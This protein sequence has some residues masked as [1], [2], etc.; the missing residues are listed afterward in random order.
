MQVLDQA[1]IP[2]MKSRPKRALLVVLA[3]LA[4]F[5][6]LVFLLIIYEQIQELNKTDNERYLKLVNAW[7]LIRQDIQ[8]WKRSSR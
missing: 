1:A 7:N 2:I 6:V 5:C 4:S 8:F 3:A